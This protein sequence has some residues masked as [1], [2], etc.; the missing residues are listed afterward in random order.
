MDGPTLEMMQRLCV[1][2]SGLGKVRYTH[3]PLSR[4][5]L[6][7]EQRWAA[8]GIEKAYRVLTT[9]LGWALMRV[10]RVQGARGPKKPRTHQWRSWRLIARGFMK[11]ADTRCR[12]LRF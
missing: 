12:R 7:A 1:D 8:D 3:D 11:C 4:L 2:R 10:E 5:D 6:T 9:G